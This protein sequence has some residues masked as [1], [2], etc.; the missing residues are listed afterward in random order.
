MQL[1]FTAI[2]HHQ[3]NAIVE[4]AR[5]IKEA[6]CHMVES[7]M[8]RLGRETAWYCLVEGNWNHIAKLEA[9]LNAQAGRI[10]CDL[11]LHRTEEEDLASEQAIAYN[12]DVV[13][14]DRV[15]ILHDLVQFFEDHGI[16]VH[17]ISTTRYPSSFG[18]TLLF[19]AHLVIKIPEQVR[20]ISLRD[21]FLDFCDQLSLDGI[22]EP[23]RR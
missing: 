21:E 10:G 4:L 3:K 7:R 12:V 6:R 18:G 9:S 22:L 1:A 19:V 23:V 16:E 20:I 13:S 14:I 15:G 11:H 2:G 8:T 5:L 17:D